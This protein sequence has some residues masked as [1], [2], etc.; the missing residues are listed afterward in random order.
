VS[1]KEGKWLYYEQLFRGFHS[2]EKDQ[3]RFMIDIFVS[4]AYDDLDS[5][6]TIV[7][8]LEKLSGTLFPKLIRGKA[9]VAV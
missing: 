8:E 1:E 5:V 2:L 7:K 6:R 9:M 3:N 4:Y